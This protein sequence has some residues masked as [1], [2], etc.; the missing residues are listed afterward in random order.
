[1]ACPPDFVCGVP[2]TALPLATAIAIQESVPMLMVRREVKAH[3]TKKVRRTKDERVDASPTRMGGKAA[4]G[5]T[6]CR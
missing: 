2:Y 6:K 4:L 3:G 1:M 5:A